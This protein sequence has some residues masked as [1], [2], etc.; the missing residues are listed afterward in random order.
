MQKGTFEKKELCR[1]IQGE[2]EGRDPVKDLN[3]EA[4]A[5]GKTK[6]L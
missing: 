6:L 1:T 3:L 5:I 4:T 2:S